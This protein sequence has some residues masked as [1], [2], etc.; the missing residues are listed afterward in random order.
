ML[1]PNG[2]PLSPFQITATTASRASACWTRGSRQRTPP[3]ATG[4]RG[5][6]GGTDPRAATRTEPWRARDGEAAAAV[7]EAEADVVV[8]AEDAGPA[9]DEEAPPDAVDGESTTGRA[10]TR[11]RELEQSNFV[12]FNAT[13]P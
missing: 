8:A 6:T 2:L 5:T 13:S 4:R 7:A 9:E 12:Q 11:E 10:A 1:L 3:R